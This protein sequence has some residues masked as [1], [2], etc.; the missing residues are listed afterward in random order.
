M[1]TTAYTR[2]SGGRGLP[3]AVRSV[4]SGLMGGGVALQMIVC[5]GEAGCLG[6]LVR[7][8]Q[9]TQ[10]GFRQ[11]ITQTQPGICFSWVMGM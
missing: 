2:L 5:L 7:C 1:F 6:F 3:S 11:E 4:S 10:A 8:L 9:G